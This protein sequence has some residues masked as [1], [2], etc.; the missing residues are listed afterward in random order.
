MNQVNLVGMSFNPV[1]LFFSLNILTASR[2]PVLVWTHFSWPSSV[3]E[4]CSRTSGV[5]IEM[6]SLGACPCHG[7]RAEFSVSQ[8]AASRETRQHGLSCRIRR[9]LAALKLWRASL[10]LFSQKPSWVVVTPRELHVVC[11]QLDPDGTPHT[12]E[13]NYAFC[14]VCCKLNK[15]GSNSAMRWPYLCNNLKEVIV[16]YIYLCFFGYNLGVLK[17]NF[18][19]FTWLFLYSSWF[20]K[21]FNFFF[22][23]KATTNYFNLKQ[24][25]TK[26]Q[27]GSKIIIIIMIKQSIILSSIKTFTKCVFVAFRT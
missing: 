16:S 21:L 14:K 10:V 7:T 15:N 2:C 25:N 8:S 5:H 26:K 4:K 27:F 20:T 12:R 18:S 23:S 22:L 17:T 19:I 3:W 1:F 24:S 13:N 6:T 9:A 11:W